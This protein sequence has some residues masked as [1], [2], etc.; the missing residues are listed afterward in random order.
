[1]SLIEKSTGREYKHSAP[2][3]LDGAMTGKN[4]IHCQSS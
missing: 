1:M 2:E 4:A 3:A